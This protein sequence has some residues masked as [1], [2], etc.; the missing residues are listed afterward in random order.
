[1]C[2][3]VYFWNYWF[4]HVSVEMQLSTIIWNFRIF[5]FRG[6]MKILAIS[7]FHTFTAKRVIFKNRLRA[8]FASFGEFSNFQEFAHIRLSP[9]W[10]NFAEFEEFSIFQNFPLL[11]TLGNFRLSTNW[12]YLTICDF[13]PPLDDP[14]FTQFSTISLN[15]NFHSFADF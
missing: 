8:I 7:D 10:D 11:T 6:K 1:V 13:L 4:L 12:E 3:C 9:I 2:V 5:N 15:D 14:Y